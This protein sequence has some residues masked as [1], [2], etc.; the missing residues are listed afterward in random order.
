M[1]RVHLW[2]RDLLTKEVLLEHIDKALC[3]CRPNF[4]LPLGKGDG[5]SLTV[6]LQCQLPHVLYTGLEDYKQCASTQLLI[7]DGLT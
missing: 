3:Q 2:I 1:L 6:L 4:V 5:K 7:L